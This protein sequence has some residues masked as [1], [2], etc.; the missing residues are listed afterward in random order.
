VGRLLIHPL[1]D[2]PQLTRGKGLKMIDIPAARLK[3]REEYVVAAVVVPQYASL[4]IIAGKRQLT[5]KQA[6]LEN[7]RQARAQRGRRLPRGLQRVDA[8]EVAFP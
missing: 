4:T 1:T 2:L 5:L 8:L 7:Y 3:A 6:D